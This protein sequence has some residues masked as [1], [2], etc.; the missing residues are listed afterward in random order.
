MIT[1]EY[2]ASLPIPPSLGRGESLTAFSPYNHSKAAPDNVPVWSHLSHLLLP[3]CCWV[4][5]TAS[6]MGASTQLDT[7][8]ALTAQHSSFLLLLQEP[9]LQRTGKMLK[10]AETIQFPATACATAQEEGDSEMKGQHIQSNAKDLRLDNC[11]TI[12]S[13][14]C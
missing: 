13:S 8:L 6:T 14:F 1:Y 4:L 10:T 2:Y 3:G 5:R 11:F 7:S 9:A 12:H